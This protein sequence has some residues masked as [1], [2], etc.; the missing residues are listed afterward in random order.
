MTK[1]VECFSIQKVTVV[2]RD[3]A[4]VVERVFSEETWVTLKVPN[5]GRCLLIVYLVTLILSLVEHYIV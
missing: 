4:L 1:F 5:Y 2:S 3:L